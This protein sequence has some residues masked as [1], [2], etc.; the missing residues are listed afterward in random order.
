[1]SEN[2]LNSWQTD[3]YSIKEATK[4]SVFIKDILVDSAH[5]APALYLS[6][7]KPYSLV[8]DHTEH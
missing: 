3:K 8:K 5:S 1:V 6:R 7:T 2:P 4:I